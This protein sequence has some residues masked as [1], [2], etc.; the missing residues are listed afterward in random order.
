LI[1][2]DFY[3]TLQQ[4]NVTLVTDAIAGLNESG[5]HTAD[6]SHHDYDVI[7]WATGFD[8]VG[9]HQWI[10]VKGVGEAEL[11]ES[12]EPVPTAYLGMAVPNFPNFFL[13]YGPNTNLGHGPITFMLER[14]AE[15]IAKA[16]AYLNKSDIE[17]LNVH[18]DSLSSYQQELTKRL[19]SSAWASPLCSSYYKTDDGTVTKNW[20]G[21]MDEYQNLV[22][23]FDPKVYVTS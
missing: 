3:P 10:P 15:Y 18:K 8:E 13:M 12:W 2:D 22:A 16:I 21:S 19:A 6:G 17:S 11:T 5:I 23:T 1:S 9:W 7:V 14:Q 4:E 20:M